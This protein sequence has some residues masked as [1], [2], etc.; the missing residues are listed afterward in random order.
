M[1]DKFPDNVIV[2]LH[3][4][5]V[6]LTCIPVQ[7]DGD[8][9]QSA[10]FYV[11]AND[12]PCLVDGQ[13]AG[14][15]FTVTFDADLHE[16]DNGTAIEIGIDIATRGAPLRGTMMFLTGHSSTQFDALK[17][18]QT[19]QDIPLF[20]GDAYCNILWQQR[21]PIS[22]A[23]RQGFTGLLDEAVARDAVIRMTGRYDPDAV[24]ADLLATHRIV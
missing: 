7:I 17:L 18:L 22:A 10:F 20:I 13:I 4:A 16:H 6:T 2:A 21:V 11:V 14:G 24:F 23:H 1:A 8:D 9:W 19:Q 5:G 12:S 3:N 15:P